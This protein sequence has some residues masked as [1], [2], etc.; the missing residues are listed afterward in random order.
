MPTPP[1]QLRQVHRRVV[2]DRLA[3]DGAASRAELATA[4]R[5]SPPTVGKVVD[6][7]ITQH[8]VEEFDP[9]MHRLQLAQYA[10]DVPQ[11]SVGRP[12][13]PLRLDS[14][15]PVIMA[16]QIGVRHTRVAA[17]PVAGPR[18]QQW[19]VTFATPR[20]AA[21]FR[22]RLATA[23]RQLRTTPRPWAVMVSAPGIVDQRAGRVLLSPNLH[24]IEKVD[25]VGLVSKVWPAATCLVQEIRA[26]AMGHLAAAPA[27][28]S[29][30]LVDFGEGVGGAAVIDGKLFQSAL[31]LSGELGHTAAPDNNRTCGCG[32]IGC[33]ETLASRRGLL[34]SFTEATGRKRATWASLKSHIA[35]QG[36]E[37]WLNDTLLKTAAIIAGGLNVLGLRD[38]VVTGALTEL[39]APIVTHLGEAIERSAMWARFGQVRCTAAPRRRAAGL[40][41]AAVD[42]VLLPVP[43]WEACG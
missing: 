33:I 40:V 32:A 15:H 19:P 8:L 38:V 9:A 26:L 41:A 4:T 28:D 31:P 29:F 1:A 27:S 5:L 24:W 12:S 6:E 14:T 30:L 21:T 13:R 17:L 35:K 2:F 7:L 18:D 16:V 34:A 10:G 22:K 23:K 36:I 3:A 20:T 39:P 25:L 37:P 42:R 11:V 43:K